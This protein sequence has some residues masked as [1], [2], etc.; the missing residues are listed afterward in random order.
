ML[1]VRVNIPDFKRQLKELGQRA[2][3]NIVRRA[4]RAAANE[5]VQ[6]ARRRA[7]VLRE[8]RKGRIRGTLQRAIRSMSRRSPR[9]EVK[10]TVGVRQTRAQARHSADPF[11][12]RFLEAGWVPRGRGQR[13]KGGRRRRA[14]ERER[15]IRGGA[16]VVRY[17][18]LSPAFESAGPR[19]LSRFNQAVTDGIAKESAK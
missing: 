9:G 4:A 12:W 3:R 17:P 16:R 8:P 10:Q 6:E 11:Y 18:F 2:E 7:P 13:F 19:A 14:L 1:E 15:A 5:F